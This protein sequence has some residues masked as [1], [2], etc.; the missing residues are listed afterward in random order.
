MSFWRR[1]YA[2][3]GKMRREHSCRI[4]VILKLGKKLSLDIRTVY[5]ILE[6]KFTQELH[7]KKKN[8]E[9]ICQ[10]LTS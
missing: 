3:E 9:S 10:C 1:L 4:P 8:R 6:T 5:L 2:I 7:W